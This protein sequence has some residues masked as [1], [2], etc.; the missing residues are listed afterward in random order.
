[1]EPTRFNGDESARRWI[2]RLSMTFI[3]DFDNKRWIK[4]VDS[5]L[6]GKAAKWADKQREIRAILRKDPTDDDKQRYIELLQERYPVEEE[7]TLEELRAQLESLK[8]GDESLKE[9]YDRAKWI[10]IDLKIKDNAISSLPSIERISLS[11]V[12]TKFVKGIQD[13]KLRHKVHQYVIF[14]EETKSLKGTYEA[15]ELQL[16]ALKAKKLAQEEEAEEARQAKADAVAAAMKDYLNGPY[17]A[18]AMQTFQASLFNC[19]GP[20]PQ[21]SMDALYTKH[22]QASTGPQYP[23]YRYDTNVATPTSST[24]N[25]PSSTPTHTYARTSDLTPRTS[26]DSALHAA[27]AVCYGQPSVSPP[28][29]PQK[30]HPRSKQSKAFSSQSDPPTPANTRNWRRREEKKG[31]STTGRETVN[32]HANTREDIAFPTSNTATN[33]DL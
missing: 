4:A 25:R 19:D 27:P 20:F 7:S 8:Q 3:E 28:V 33:L 12:I 11:H 30:S 21:A 5:L 17:T 16:R 14:N 15:S 32:I 26:T 22:P 2:D 13:R 31:P 10:L 23:G 9:Y 6:A 18:E 24:S 29:Q 1:M